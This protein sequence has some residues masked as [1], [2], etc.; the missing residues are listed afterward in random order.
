MSDSKGRLKMRTVMVL[1]ALVPMVVALL[2]VTFVV[3]GK[4]V[5]TVEENIKEELRV[6]SESLKEYY[7]YDLEEGIDLEDGFI[8]YQTDYIDYMHKTG[9][10]FTIFKGDVRF[11]TTIRDDKGERIEGTKASP[12]VWKEVRSG[13]DYYSDDVVINGVDYY[14]YYVPIRVN[15]DVVGMAFSGK[16]ADLV[17][18]AQRS[19][20]IFIASIALGFIALFTVLALVIVRKMTTP[21]V[22]VVKDIEKISDG[23]TNVETTS[24]SSIAEISALVGASNKLSKILKTSI[25]NIKENSSSLKSVIENTTA[26]VNT[27]TTRTQEIK[28]A[29]GEL[30]DSTK[31]LDKNIGNIGMNIKEMTDMMNEIFESAKKLDS[32]AKEISKVSKEASE[33]FSEMTEDSRLSANAVDDI[34]ESVGRTNESISKIGDMVS[35]ITDIASQTNLLALNASI[36][37]ARAGESGRGFGVVATE[38]KNLAEQS[39]KSAET[40]RNI[41]HEIIQQS[42]QMTEKSSKVKSA[43]EAEGE[44]LRSTQDKFNKLG[45]N[46]I[47]SV[48]EINSI[49]GKTERLNSALRGVNE[50]SVNISSISK[51]NMKTNNDVLSAVTELAI[52][53]GNVNTDCDKMRTSA[54][55]MNDAVAYFK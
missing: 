48:T 3:G 45:D 15:R 24:S 12:E 4:M 10:D 30:A 43:I 54:N 44:T 50:A 18:S 25:V 11:A 5:S 33:S 42:E 31:L 27:S 9:L 32:V 46:I 47:M 36:E 16:T 34:T 17:H 37:A 41:V 52:N 38:I 22:E 14:V 13:R 20:Y 21:L 51:E 28:G 1:T 2:T 40:I 8:E 19:I 35:I 29:T 49:S 23:Y 39:S 55:S 53:M 6:A 26:F 7:Q